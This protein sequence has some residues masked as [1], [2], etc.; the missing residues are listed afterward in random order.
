[1]IWTGLGGKTFFN[2]LCMKNEEEVAIQMMEVCI[3]E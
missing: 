2:E 3:S 1:M